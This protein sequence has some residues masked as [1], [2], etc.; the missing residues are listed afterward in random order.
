MPGKK[1]SGKSRRVVA[2]G[3]VGLELD[4]AV[5][6]VSRS[7]AGVVFCDPDP[8]RILV[9]DG[10]LGDFVRRPGMG[11][12]VLMR[13]LVREQDWSRYEARYKPG[14]RQPYHPAAMMS[15]ILLG[16]MTGRTSLR[17]LEHLG[18]TDL[19]AWWLTGGVMPDYSSLCRFINRHRE[20][21]TDTTFENLTRAMMTKLGSTAESLALDGT[22]V[23]AAASR[24]RTLKQ[25]AA[26]QAAT[27]ARAA[28]AAAPNDVALASRAELAEQAAKIVEQRNAARAAKGRTAEASVAPSEPEAVIQPLKQGGTAPSYKPS[29]AVNADRFITGHDVDPSNESVQVGKILDQ[30]QRV[31][32]VAAIEGLMDSGYCNA[33]V[34]EAAEQRKLD[35]LCPEGRATDAQGGSEKK[36]K[37]FGKAKFEYDA[38][39]DA[40][41]CPAGRLLKRAHRVKAI[42]SNPGH[43][44]YRSAGC[45]DCPL[46]EQCKKPVT[47]YRTLQRYDH[48]DKKE[49]HR[50][51]MR[52]PDVKERYRKRQGRVEPV[53]GEQK[54][55]QGMLRF[56]RRGL[57]KVKLEYSLH[58][59]A[60]N[61]RRF[62]AICRRRARAGAGSSRCRRRGIRPERNMA[63]NRPAQRRHVRRLPPS[64]VAQ[65][66]PL[67]YLGLRRTSKPGM[68]EIGLL[69]HLQQPPSRE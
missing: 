43:T 3:Q 23:Q 26:A 50:E 39:Q 68:P 20:D 38:G 53:H 61:L 6:P 49:A 46:A 11:W 66:W 58:C 37:Y 8:A 60:H 40:Y 31:A 57:G 56:R 7:V 25:E 54:H 18:R 55:I 12:V 33:T 17:Q 32:G 59:M 64:L 22:V 9:G 34:F 24:L 36:T 65:R 14:G 13:K 10:Y 51:K 45:R 21:L 52:E 16:F 69:R 62:V 5:V 41:L 27:E 15:L 4:A 28:A 1:G 67:C 2:G 30:S 19:Q 44:T 48:D 29:V 63:A 35:L 47:I 42:G